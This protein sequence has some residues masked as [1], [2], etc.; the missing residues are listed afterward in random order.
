MGIRSER[1]AHGHRCCMCRLLQRQCV[2]GA[3][4]VP[5]AEL[6]IQRTRGR[7]PFY[8]GQAHDPRAPNF[9]FN[10][11]HEVTQSAARD[12]L[13]SSGNSMVTG[14]ISGIMYAHKGTRQSA[15]H[16]SPYHHRVTM[17]CWHRSQCASVAWTWQ[18]RNRCDARS[19]SHWRPSSPTSSGSSPLQRCV[20]RTVCKLDGSSFILQALLL[21]AQAHAFTH[22]LLAMS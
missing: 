20:P 5:F 9:N 3:L 21:R 8:A 11:S 2:A 15:T 13:A 12:L 7:K 6:T 18:H 1:L 14:V 16:G 10:V 22:V 17:W 19:R 4:G